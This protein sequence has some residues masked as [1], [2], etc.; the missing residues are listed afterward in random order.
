MTA[1]CCSSPGG[2]VAVGTL[3][4]GLRVYDGSGRARRGWTSPSGLT[5]VAD[6]LFLSE[7]ELAVVD[8]GYSAEAPLLSMAPWDGSRAG[9]SSPCESDGEL[10]VLASGL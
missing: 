4:G 7:D 6:A 8:H 10:R 3:G 5:A 2:L 1:L 9:S